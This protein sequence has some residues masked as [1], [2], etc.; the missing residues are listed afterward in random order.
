[1]ETRKL[2]S[3]LAQNCAEMQL[4]NLPKVKSVSDGMND[5]IRVKE[6]GPE[7]DAMG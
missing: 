7:T 1:V 4:D 2:S 6:Q 3:L 5:G